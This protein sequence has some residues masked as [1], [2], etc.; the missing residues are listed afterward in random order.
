M[1][2]DGENRELM[3]GVAWL[4]SMGSVNSC[5][6]QM[7]LN[8]STMTTDE[9]IMGTL[10]I[11]AVRRAS[12]PSTREAS[13]TS[14]GIA[15]SA[16]KKITEEYPREVHTAMFTTAGTARLTLR[17]SISRFSEPSASVIGLI[18]GV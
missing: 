4:R 12:A 6:V 7:V 13:S 2:I 1:Y 5:R 9:R 8:S 14:R 16:A 10:T 15:W 18:S 17:K 11:T 3:A